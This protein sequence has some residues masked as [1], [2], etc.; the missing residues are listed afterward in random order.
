MNNND[1]NNNNERI[2]E[3]MQRLN[4]NE[5]ISPNNEHGS[6]NEMNVEFNALSNAA[7]GVATLGNQLGEMSEHLS[8]SVQVIRR[9]NIENERS[10]ELVRND[11]N[12]LAIRLNNNNNIEITTI[13]RTVAS[14]GLIGVLSYFGFR[15]INNYIS[16]YIEG[17]VVIPSAEIVSRR[18]IRFFGQTIFENIFENIPKNK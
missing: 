13:T 14:T 6:S 18:T 2:S 8:E 10:L 12:Q 7:S 9:N 1:N 4:N 11:N 3:I 5:V 16:N 17:S 15:I